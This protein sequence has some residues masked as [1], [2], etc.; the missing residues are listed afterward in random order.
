M[1][2]HFDLKD[3]PKVKPLVLDHFREF[4][5]EKSSKTIDAARAKYCSDDKLDHK[6]QGI[7]NFAIF[8][9]KGFSIHYR[10]ADDVKKYFDKFT[11]FSSKNQCFFRLPDSPN[12]D[13]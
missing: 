8:L 12:F 3:V 7:S 10:A 6:S 11:K 2:F 13:L 4:T 5:V 1:H 9:K